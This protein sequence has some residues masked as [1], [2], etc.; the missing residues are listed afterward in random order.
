M[1]PR[2]G[3]LN[4]RGSSPKRGCVSVAISRAGLEDQTSRISLIDDVDGNNEPQR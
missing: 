2:G 3:G 1:I 4:V